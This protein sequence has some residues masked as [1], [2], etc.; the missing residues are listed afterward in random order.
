MVT[1]FSPTSYLLQTTNGPSFLA[2]NMTLGFQIFRNFPISFH[3]FEKHWLQQWQLYT[4]LTHTRGLV[5][6]D[7][8]RLLPIN[9]TYNCILS[10]TDHHESD[11][12]I[13]QPFSIVIS[14]FITAYFTYRPPKI[15]K[16]M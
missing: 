2:Q 5:T 9:S 13:V 12:C 10:I 3:L 7:L 8:M 16:I 15:V 1:I 4:P 11:V 14:I 6:M